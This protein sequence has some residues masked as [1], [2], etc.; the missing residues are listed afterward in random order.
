MDIE[1]KEYEQDLPQV[2]PIQDGELPKW[3]FKPRRNP[4]WGTIEKDGLIV[5][6]GVTRKVVPPDEVYKLAALGCS[7]EEMCDWFQINRETLKYNFAEYISKGQSHLKQRLRQAQYQVAI[8][9]N[10]TMLIWLGKNV[11]GQQ[12]TPTNNDS[13]QPLPWN[14]DTTI[15]GETDN[16]EGTV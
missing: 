14:D 15:P 3:E 12:E 9:G 11:L 13:N 16:G 2:A 7:M 5:G 6:R 8:G 1:D 4:K 10:A